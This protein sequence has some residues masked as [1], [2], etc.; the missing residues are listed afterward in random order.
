MNGSREAFVLGL[1]LTELTLIL[2]F[3]LLLLVSV[4]LSK[5]NTAARAREKEHQSLSE[6]IREYDTTVAEIF[7]GTA[8]EH[9]DL[10]E[11]K[12]E[13]RELVEKSEIAQEGS[14]RLQG[15]KEK[16]E[17]QLRE[18]KVDFSRSE[19]EYEKSKQ[20]YEKR[21]DQLAAELSTL[22]TSKDGDAAAK[23]ADLMRRQEKENRNLKGQLKNLQRR[24][25]LGKG[26]IDWPPCWADDNGRPEYLYY[27]VINETNLFIE[28][29]WPSVRDE[30]VTEIPGALALLGNTTEADFKRRAVALLE[31]S[32]EKECRHFVQ[33]YNRATTLKSYESK[34]EA[35][36]TVFYKFK[37]KDPRES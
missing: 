5:Q 25:S 32:K 8:L 27:I 18:V 10:I 20:E 23:I 14:E 34:M 4:A 11:D 30:D 36:E 3:V 19:R 33:I 7:A 6:K 9:S 21:L 26:G 1:T 24:C 13:F 35:I 31:E 29:A 28:K 22:G 37:R 16:L 12:D 17:S 2:F 15:E